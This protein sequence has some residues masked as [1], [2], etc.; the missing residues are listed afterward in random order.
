MLDP[1]LV[2]LMNS[3]NLP[4]S[5]AWQVTNVCCNQVI[6]WASCFM[7]GSHMIS[8]TVNCSKEYWP[9]WS[10]S[11]YDHYPPT[12][13]EPYEFWWVGT[14]ADSASMVSRWKGIE[15]MLAYITGGMPKNPRKR[16]RKHCQQ[17]GTPS[18]ML[19]P[20]QR[21]WPDTDGQKGPSGGASAGV[22]QMYFCLSKKNIGFEKVKYHESDY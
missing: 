1:V 19:H 17:W 7:L 3:T 15:I 6:I 20:S 18:I 13:F 11:F 8:S 16:S 12:S 2:D 9:Y 21:T 4:S 22:V 10:L 14:K 5:S